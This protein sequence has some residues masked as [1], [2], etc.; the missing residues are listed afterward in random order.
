MYVVPCHLP[1][2]VVVCIMSFLL[3]ID[4]ENVGYIFL[5]LKVTHLI[6]S[7]NIKPLLKTRHRNTSETLEKTMEESLSLFSLRISASQ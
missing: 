6:N 5:K 2:S 4:Q 1:H 7:K 3:T